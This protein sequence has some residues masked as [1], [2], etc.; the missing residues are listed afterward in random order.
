MAAPRWR[1]VD[2]VG[3]RQVGRE[4]PVLEDLVAHRPERPVLEDLAGL[5]REDLERPRRDWRLGAMRR[6]R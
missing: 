6:L 5:V 3:R 1:R 2:L 4:R